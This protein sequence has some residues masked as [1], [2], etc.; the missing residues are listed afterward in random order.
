[1]TQDA[2]AQEIERLHSFFED[3]FNGVE[4]RTI[5][6]FADSLDDGFYIVSPEG[7]MSNAETI[8]ETVDS[9]RGAWP[10]QIQIEQVYIRSDEGECL[11]ATY[12]EHQSSATRSAVMLSTV[13]LVPDATR[14]GGFRW[15]F[16]HESWLVPP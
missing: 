2:V 16:V 12:E 9:R 7:T 1:M 3:W 4:G 10:V 15:L 5:S 14:P 8:V 6:E 11:I 13:G